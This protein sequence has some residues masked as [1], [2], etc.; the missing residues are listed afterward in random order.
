MV[1]GGYI[2]FAGY[3]QHLDKT[4]RIELVENV[5][6]SFCNTEHIY[7]IMY[8]YDKYKIYLN[9]AQII[10]TNIFENEMKYL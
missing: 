7:Y 8:L 2:Q 3:V 9:K 5:F 6:V 1:T 10:W 4:L